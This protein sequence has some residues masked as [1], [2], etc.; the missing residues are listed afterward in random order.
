MLPK[1]LNEHLITIHNKERIY[2][3][4]P[5][6]KETFSNKSNMRRHFKQKHFH[7]ESKL[8]TKKMLPKNLN[9][10][11]ITIHNKERIY[12]PCPDCKENFKLGTGF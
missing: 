4:C 12:I 8:C 1:N 6:C 2:I 10:H 7:K 9:E 3:P 5:D 11:L